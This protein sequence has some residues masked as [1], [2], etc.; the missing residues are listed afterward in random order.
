LVNLVSLINLVDLVDLKIKSERSNVQGSMFKVQGSTLVDL[1]CLV[2]LVGITYNRSYFYE[3]RA[4]AC[5]Q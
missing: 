2:C 5:N 4:S 1:V 3:I